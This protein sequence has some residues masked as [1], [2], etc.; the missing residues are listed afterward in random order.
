[1][2]PLKVLNWS[3]SHVFKLLEKE[4]ISHQY[5]WG[6]IFYP[7]PGVLKLHLLVWL[8]H[9]LMHRSNFKSCWSI[10]HFTFSCVLLP[11]NSLSKVTLTHLKRRIISSLVSI[12]LL[13]DRNKDL[14][15]KVLKRMYRGGE[16]KEYLKL[17]TWKLKH[18]VCCWRTVVH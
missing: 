12:S 17:N 13:E 5:F 3:N 9:S 1:M 18:S 15:Q 8:N 7:A 11:G 16:R 2:S 4:L 14:Y 6:G 10:Y